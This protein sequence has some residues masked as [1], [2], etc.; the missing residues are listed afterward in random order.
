[1]KTQAVFP[2]VR[3]GL[4][5]I[6]SL[7]P[8]EWRLHE[9]SGWTL[10]GLGIA[11]RRR[12]RSSHTKPTVP[13]GFTL[14]ELLV[15]IAIIA[16]LA[17]LLLPALSRA[18]EKGRAT[19]CRNNMRQIGLGMFMYADDNEDFF[20]WPPGHIPQRP[21]WCILEGEGFGD[22]SPLHA[23][24]GSVFP[25]VIGQPRV[26]IPLPPRSPFWSD[27]V[28]PDPHYTNSFRVYICPG[29]GK[30]GRLNRV[31][32]YLNWFCSLSSKLSSPRGVR[33]GAVINPAQKVLLSDK[34]WE[35]L[36]PNEW[37]GGQC[38][39]YMLISTNQIRHLG[40]LNVVFFD[41]HVGTFSKE[42]A[43]Q[44]EFSRDLLREY[45]APFELLADEQ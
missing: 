37:H 32:Y 41:G 22:L 42:R 18:K 8:T 24:A 6:E 38:Y 20:P 40:W 13:Q 35:V 2:P 43:V 36:V 19:Y 30:I 17:S 9:R 34:T 45:I 31:T 12:S 4:C 26:V 28:A 1:M 21:E 27:C 10:A 7:L 15:V 11:P 44:I 29:S 3:S 14:I 16:I 33:R 23:E 25:Y 39:E 5:L